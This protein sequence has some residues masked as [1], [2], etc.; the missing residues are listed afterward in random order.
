[1]GK[2]QVDLNNISYKLDELSSMIQDH[3][4]ITCQECNCDLEPDDQMLYCPD[5][6][7]AD[8]DK[9]KELEGEVKELKE[10]LSKASWSD[11]MDLLHEWAIDYDHSIL[12]NKEREVWFNKYDNL[13]RGVEIFRA[14]LRNLLD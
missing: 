11:K 7:E 9:I 2:L 12:V 13:F 14:G 6:V 5:C 10:E 8:R 3:L 4:G 1:M